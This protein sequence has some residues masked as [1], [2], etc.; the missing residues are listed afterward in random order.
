VHEKIL[1]LTGIIALLLGMTGC[2]IFPGHHKTV[3]VTPA[4]APA[5]VIVE[6]AHP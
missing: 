6:P 4:P 1:L 5:P 2:I 3:V